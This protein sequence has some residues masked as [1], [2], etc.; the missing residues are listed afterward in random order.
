MSHIDKE[1]ME[2]LRTGL[3]AELAALIEELSDRGVKTGDS[4]SATSESEGEEADPAD[5]A[6]NIEELITN[7]PLVED[8]KKREKEIKGA[9]RRMEEGTYGTCEECGEEIPVER[10]EANPA[11]AM[12]IR[13][14]E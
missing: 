1:M 13:H 12:C 8:L 5:A 7:V 2:D 3:E 6:D 14:A 4:W 10:L 11:A 9:M